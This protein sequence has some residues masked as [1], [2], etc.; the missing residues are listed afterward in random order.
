LARP[1]T[2]IRI[3]RRAATRSGPWPSQTV[4]G[5]LAVAPPV[6]SERRLFTAFEARLRRFGVRPDFPVLR[7]RGRPEAEIAHMVRPTADRCLTCL[8]EDGRGAGGRWCGWR[9]ARA[10]RL[11][12]VP[13]P[14]PAAVVPADHVRRAGRGVNVPL[15]AAQRAACGDAGRVRAAELAGRAPARLAGLLGLAV[16]PFH[17]AAPG[18]R[19]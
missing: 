15:P 1:L 4:I 19:P 2:A 14:L 16:H 9:A 11:A 6:S 10:D 18:R 7:S 12:G 5:S 17:G 8:S 3:C 13:V